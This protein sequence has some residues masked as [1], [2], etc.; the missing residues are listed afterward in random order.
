MEQIADVFDIDVLELMS[1]GEKNIVMYHQESDN[2]S[3]NIICNSEEL[4]QQIEYL[5]LQLDHKNELIKAK[6][7]IIEMQRREN[8]LLR[9]ALEKTK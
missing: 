4:A 9:E 2:Q 5:K 7:E 3:L 8:A 6:D 1:V